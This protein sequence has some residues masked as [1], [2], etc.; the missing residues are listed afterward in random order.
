MKK[1]L[2]LITEQF[3]IAFEEKGYDKSLTIIGV[4]N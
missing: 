1:I 3:E 4:S 2:E